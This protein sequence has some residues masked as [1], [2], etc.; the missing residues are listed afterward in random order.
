MEFLGTMAQRM[1]LMAEIPSL[2]APATDELGELFFEMGEDGRKFILLA[3]MCV[4][5]VKIGGHRIGWDYNHCGDH[6]AENDYLSGKQWSV[7]EIQ[8]DVAD[9]INQ[10][11]EMGW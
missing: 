4:A 5:A 3:A 2:R 9:V 1:R 7:P 11:N 8:E 10:L 6:N